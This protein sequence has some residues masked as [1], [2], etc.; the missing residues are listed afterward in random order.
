[1]MDCTMIRETRLRLGLTVGQAGRLFDI[2]P[3]NWTRIE[4]GQMEA[5]GPLTRLLLLADRSPEVVLPLLQEL[6]SEDR[7]MGQGAPES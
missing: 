7:C 5:R 6:A 4:S 3:R 1:M 2:G